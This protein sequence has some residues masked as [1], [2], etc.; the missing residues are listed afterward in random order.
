MSRQPR[1]LFFLLVTVLPAALGI[2]LLVQMLRE[3]PSG[4]PLV[5]AVGDLAPA[6]ALSLQA[7]MAEWVGHD[8]GGQKMPPTMM[9]G[10]PEEGQRRLHVELTLRNSRGAGAGAEMARARE[11]RLISAH[12]GSWSALRGS[13]EEAAVGP[14]QMRTEDLYFDVPEQE[15]N[16]QDLRLVWSRGGRKVYVILAADGDTAHQERHQ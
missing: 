14:G 13:F 9:P 11:F 15:A 10:M 16:L 12:G 6:G 7:E 8:M 4:P 2:A 3:R 5:V 1:W